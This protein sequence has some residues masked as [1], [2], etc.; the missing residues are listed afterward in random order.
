MIYGIIQIDLDNKKHNVERKDNL[1]ML[2]AAIEKGEDLPT[3]TVFFFIP[4]GKEHEKHDPAN[5]R[6][7]MKP[8]L[9]KKH[10][11]HYQTPNTVESLLISWVPFNISHPTI[12]EDFC[13][14]IFH[15]EV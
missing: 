4:N 15:H 6:A 7:T 10:L 12:R 8:G 3:R 11:N 13:L 1:K 5:D 2:N 9:V 14:K